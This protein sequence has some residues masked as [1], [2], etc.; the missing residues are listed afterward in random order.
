[1]SNTETTRP[2]RYC[3]LPLLA[4]TATNTALLPISNEHQLVTTK[5]GAKAGNEWPVSNKYAPGYC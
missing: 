3:P 4:L 5:R 2:F 1:M